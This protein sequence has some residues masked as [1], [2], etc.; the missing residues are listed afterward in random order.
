MGK[1]HLTDNFPK[2][3]SQPAILALADAGFAKLEDLAGASEA[4]LLKLH[5]MGP[6]AIPI[7]QQGLSERGLKPL[8]P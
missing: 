4:E 7:I 3:V 6:K 2:G 5:G 8:R 1:H